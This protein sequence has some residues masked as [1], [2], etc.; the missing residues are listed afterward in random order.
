MDYQTTLLAVSFL[1]GLT[2]GWVQN[3]SQLKS[4]KEELNRKSVQIL[5]LEMNLEK[6]RSKLM[7][8]DYQ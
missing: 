7:W 1:L 4:L 5:D 8:K 2:V 6:S 3:L